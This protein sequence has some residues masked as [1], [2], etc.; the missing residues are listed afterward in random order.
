[1]V[2]IIVLMIVIA[3]GCIGS[4]EKA[5]TGSPSPEQSITST[6]LNSTGWTQSSSSFNTSTRISRGEI[7]TTPVEVNLSSRVHLEIDPRLELVEIIYFLSNPE[8]YQ[9]HASPYLTGVNPYNYPYMKD[10]IEYFKNYT[11]ATAVRMVPTMVENG[12]VYDAIPEFALHLSPVNFSKAMNWS[13]MLRLRP[14]LNVTLLNEFA[15][16]VFQFAKETDFWKFYDEHRAFYNKILQAFENNGKTILNVTRFEEDFFGEKASSWTIVPL[17]LIAYHGFGYHLNE[18]GKREIYAFLG[19][20]RVENGVPRVYLTSMG[21]TF[22]VHEFA[23]SFVNPAVDE[24]YYLFEPYRSLYNP[25][26]E[27]LR[28]MAYPDFKVMLYETFV[29][30]VEVYYLNSTGHADEAKRKLGMYSVPF[31]FIKEVYSAYVND[32]MKH[33]NKYRNYTDFMPELA[34]VVRE[35]YNRTD[36]GKEVEAP[37]TVHDFIRSAN[38]TG[39]IVAYSLG[40]YSRR[41]AEV[42][43]RWLLS[44]GINATLKPVS[45]LTK[46]ELRGNLMLVLYSNSSL[47][48]ELNR[49]A[50]VTVNGRKFH[51]KPSG[52][53]YTGELEVFEIFKNPWNESSLVYLTIGTDERAFYSRGFIRRSYLTYSIVFVPTGN[54]FEWA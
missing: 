23:H 26:S 6:V 38:L 8:W 2:V 53:T 3:G 32:Y 33:R 11:N 52:E 37:M 27:K 46:K 10:V 28:M 35:V 16:A 29:R 50:L 18:N 13:D 25:V 47:L 20:G 41:L 14:W 51:S 7:T 44:F 42:E 31:Y 30:A 36:G 15:K 5:S 24:Y 34:K 17:T 54:V 49:N 19:F 48:K 1:M 4:V 22:L 12:L 9:R 43:Y 39:A 40:E 45:K 21:I